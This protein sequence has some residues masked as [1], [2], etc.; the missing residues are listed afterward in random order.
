MTEL[1]FDLPVIC[2]HRADLQRVLVQAFPSDRLHLQRALRKIEPTRERVRA[3]FDAGPVIEADLLIGAD[4]L[5]SVV[6][7]HIFRDKAPRYGG[8]TAWRGFV[9]LPTGLLTKGEG[10]ETLGEGVRMGIVP[11]GAERVGWWIAHNEPADETDEP[12]GTRAKLLSLCGGWH[13][14]IHALITLTD[15]IV[16]TD[17]YDRKPRRGW[18]RGRVALLG[19]AAHPTTPNLGQ[20]G[21]MAIEDAIILARCLQTGEYL[22]SALIRYENARFDRTRMVATESRLFGWVGQL[23]HPLAA[24]LRNYYLSRMEKNAGAATFLKYFDYDATHVSI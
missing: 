19:D 11:L 8:Y 16:K 13:P 23:E 4:G 20:G 12:E 24:R 10:G 14:P 21:C 15:D 18:S 6:R 2:M 7:E 17:I 5:R 1:K 3:H 22:E 9:E